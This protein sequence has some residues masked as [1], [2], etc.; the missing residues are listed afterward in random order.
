MRFRAALATL[1][2]L[3]LAACGSGTTANLTTGT[4]SP[5]SGASGTSTTEPSNL[6]PAVPPASVV[7]APVPPGELP[8]PTGKIGEK[9]TLTFPAGNPPPSLQRLVLSEGSG[10]VVA[11]KDFLVTNYL[12]QVWG[13]KVFDNS[14][15]KKKTATFQIGNGKVVP[16]WD[17]ALV[18]VKV[19]S[20]VMLSLPPAD[21][22]GPGGNSGAGIK[23]TDTL[24]FVIDVVSDVAS[25]KTG[26]PDA[27]VQPAPKDAPVVTGKPG[28]EPKITIPKG[29]KAPA[30]GAAYLL[31]KGTGAP[32]REGNVLAQ[33]VFTDWTQTQTQSTWPKTGAA[34]ATADPA[35]AGLQTVPVAKGGPL[36]GLAGMPLGSRAMVLIPGTAASGT[37][38]AQAATVAVLDLVAQ[39]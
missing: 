6:G 37:A 4:S 13:G 8:K 19:G 32:V 24:V 36:A 18:G 10:G 39:G 29:L 15:D 35:T 27:V 23:G 21:G 1:P 38:Q 14:Y 31:A 25:T 17:T 16:G 20:R 34:A 5:S 12:G 9:P 28:L 2:L 22:Y 11:K 33:L 7:A 30:K 26:Q 3:V